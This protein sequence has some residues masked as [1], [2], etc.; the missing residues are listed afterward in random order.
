MLPEVE[1]RLIASLGDGFGTS[2]NLHEGLNYPGINLLED[3]W[4]KYRLDQFFT[5]HPHPKIIFILGGV[6]LK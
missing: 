1:D 4:P 3:N 2:V 6:R 5:L